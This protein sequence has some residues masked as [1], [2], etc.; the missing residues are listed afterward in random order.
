MKRIL[1]LLLILIGTCSVKAQPT[2]SPATPAVRYELRAV[3]LTTLSGLDWPDR[4]ATSEA[5]IRRQQEDL[6]RMLDRIKEAGLNTVL[7]QARIRSTTAYP[8]AIEPWDGAFSGTP[9]QSP[10][11]DPLAFAVKACHDRGLECHA[12]VVAFPICK[13]PVAKKLGK[14]ALPAIHPELCRKCGDQW[15]MDP[16]VPGTA[17]YLARICREIVENYAVDGIHL[18]YIRY[19]EQAIS[20]NDDAT[21]RRYGGGQSRSK[22]RTDNVD[23]CVREI[24]QAVKSVR[25]WVKMSCSPVGKYSDLSRY[26]SYGWNA[27]DAVNQDARR[28]LREGW[29]DWLLPMMY[30]DGKHYYPFLADWQENAAG[31]IVAPGLGIYFLNPKEKDWPLLTVRRQLNVARSEG[32]GGQAYFRAKFLLNNEKGL[33]DW[34]RNDYYREPALVP[35]MSWVDSPQPAAPKVRQSIDGQTLRLDWAPVDHRTPVTYNVYRLD[36]IYGDLL[37]ASHLS[38]P[39]YEHLLHLPALKHSR[40]VVTTVDAYGKESEAGGST[41]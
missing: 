6:C 19:P 34:L 37:L 41:Q 38:A 30:F 27:R 33:Y 23:R 39:H 10:G 18:D 24:S 3:W 40:Y 28:W 35:P 16:G 25:P 31:R 2:H 11:Y 36:S 26:S 8:S 32:L 5:Q 20:F 29:M 13:V 22:W 7:F 15:M 9:G 12:W 17:P 14:K 1:F 4:P 21:Y